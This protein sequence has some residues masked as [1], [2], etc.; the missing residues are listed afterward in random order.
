[1]RPRAGAALALLAI[2]ALASFLRMSALGWGLRHEPDWDERVFVQSAAW[3]V[4]SGDL[5]HRFYEYPALF[6]Y[7]LAPVIA[8]HGPP[9]VGPDAYLAARRLVAAFGVISVILV[10]ALGAR[11]GGRTVGLV[12][13]LLLAVS[14][15]DVQ[16]AHEVRPDVVLGT[17]FL[18]ALLVF[19]LAALRPFGDWICGLA[20]GAATA[21]KF[22]GA[23]VAP[24]CLVAIGSAPE[25]RREWWKGALRAAIAAVV[26]YAVLSPYTFLHWEKFREG[27]ATQL[28]YHYESRESVRTYWGSVW[29]DVRRLEHSFGPLALA[30][31]AA[32]VWVASRDRRYWPSLV[33]PLIVI[34]VMNTADVTWPRFLVPITGTLALAAGCLTATVARRFGGFAALALALS[35]A[36]APA[37][38]SARY[39]R[40]LGQPGTWDRAVSWI[41]ANVRERA[42][43]LTTVKRMGLDR[44]RY[45]VLLADTIDVRIRRW[46]AHMDY[47]VS[48]PQDDPAALTGFDLV[49]TFEPLPDAPDSTV[50]VLVPHVPAAREYDAVP[51][52]PSALS[53]SE[54]AAAAAAMLD[55]VP[56]TVWQTEGP[57]IPGA[58]WIE[59]RLSG[60]PTIG[61]IVVDLGRHYRRE[62]KNL[63]VFVADGD[64]PWRR[65]QA[66]PGRAPVDRQPPGDHSLEYVLDPVP[67][68]GLRLV[69]VGSAGRPWNVAELRID[70]LR[71]AGE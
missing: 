48:G 9:D 40:A 67:A 47:L 23:L 57:Q 13:A 59:V 66:F 14:P 63:H 50:R 61:R 20:V 1:M 43:I 36:A 8:P 38:Q 17:F 52:A 31:M 71:T 6:I 68:T 58:S 11:L 27:A 3:M 2:V 29:H 30:L 56:D 5:D 15:L 42:R 51:L 53:V 64:T 21:V 46:A 62:P 54:N 32:G 35:A 55:H 45:D 65:V 12:A 10:F 49:E 19:D 24:S 41:D 16:T 33:L 60:R 69:Q 39:V 4:A 7:L 25:A 26:L 44:S 34:G 18:G 28:S 70:A 22:S 37:L